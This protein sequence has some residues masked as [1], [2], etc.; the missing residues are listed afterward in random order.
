[1]DEDYFKAKAIF[2]YM[3]QMLAEGVAITHKKR[4]EMIKEIK[5]LNTT[6]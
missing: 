5:F 6:S 1:M 3:A 2:E 4:D